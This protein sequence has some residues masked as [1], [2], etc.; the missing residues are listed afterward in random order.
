MIYP[1]CMNHNWNYHSED[2]PIHN[3][4]S[5][6]VNNEMAPTLLPQK[7]QNYIIVVI[8]IIMQHCTSAINTTQYLQ[9]T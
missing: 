7:M 4:T 6:Q 8:C 5:H 9:E 2:P 1:Q 3:V